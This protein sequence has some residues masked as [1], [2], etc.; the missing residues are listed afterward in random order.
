MRYRLTRTLREVLTAAVRWGYIARNPAVDAGRN[1][2]PRREELYPFTPEELVALD[3]EFSNTD[4]ALVT[5]AA[6]TGLRTN[7][8]AGL[9]RRDVDRSGAVPVVLVQRRVVRGV[10]TPYPKNDA[11]RR[12]VPLSADALAAL[13]RMPPRLDT[14]V[15]FPSPR[16]RLPDAGQLAH[17]HLVSRA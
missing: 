17:A 16:R 11:G 4:A 8:W 15:I 13:D 5:F 9:E 14:P 7:E 2:E 10:M 3:A 12:R 6:A 1:P